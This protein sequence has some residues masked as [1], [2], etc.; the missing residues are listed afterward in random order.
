MAQQAKTFENRSSDLITIK[1][2]FDRKDINGMGRFAMLSSVII[3]TLMGGFTGGN[4]YTAFLTLHDFSIVDVG[5]IGVLPLLASCFSVFGPMILERFKK[6]KWVLAAGRLVY[7]IINILGTTLMPF[8]THTKEQA[9][10]FLGAI[11]FLG[12][13]VNYL[14]ASGYTVWHLKFIEGPVRARYYAISQLVSALVGSGTLVGVGLLADIILA[15]PNAAEIITALRF[16]GFA[17]AILDVIVLTIPKEYPYTQ[18]AQINLK[19]VFLLPIKSPKFLAT[20][21]ILMLWGFSGALSGSAFNYYVLNTVKASV[22]V[23]NLFTPFNMVFLFLFSK[24]WLRVLDKFSWLKTF[25]LCAIVEIIGKG[26]YSF[27]TS[28]NYLWLYTISLVVSA[29]IGVGLNIAYTGL[30]YMHMPEHDTT[31]FITFYTLA[32]TLSSFA[33]QSIG[34]AL[35]SIIGDWS[36]QMLGMSWGA[37]QVLTLATTVGYSICTLICFKLNGKLAVPMR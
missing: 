6:R 5:I 18:Q 4:L 23:M 29:F 8:V 37:V 2:V 20:T 9:V 25:A 19:N 35:L 30:P 14:F 16:V 12:G 17:L 24:Y 26:V 34:T 28:D 36:F 32:V 33:G 31:Y 1:E 10:V 3:G 27:V 15:K 7:Y 13:L 11:M 22:T 21:L